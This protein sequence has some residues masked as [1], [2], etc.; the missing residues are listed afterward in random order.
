MFAEHFRPSLMRGRRGAILGAAIACAGCATY[1]PKPLTT[2]AVNQALA[3]PDDD[4]LHVQAHELHHPILAPIDLNLNDGLLPDEAAV[5]AVLMNPGLRAKRDERGLAQ[6]QVLQAG[7]LPNPQISASF[8]QPIGGSTAGTVTGFGGGLDYDIA[9]LITRGAQIDSAKAEAASIELDV[10]WQE[11]LVAEDAKLHVTR[12]M[13][14]QRQLD[15]TATAHQQAQE[16]AATLRNAVQR[17]MM[18]QVELDAAETELQRFRLMSLEAE[19][20]IERERLALNESIGLPAQTTI[21]IQSNHSPQ[22]PPALPLEQ[23]TEHL[24]DRR[25]DLMALRFGYESQEAKLRVAVLSQFPKVSV[26][27]AAAR[28]TGNVVSAGMGIT[29]D[30]PIFDRAQGAIS[31]ESATRQKLFDEY[32]ARLFEARSDIAKIRTELASAARKI[33]ATDAYVAN[34]QVLQQTYSTAVRNGAADIL[35]LYQLQNTLAD[36]RLEGM[37]LRQLQAEL[38]IG[39]ELAQGQIIPRAEP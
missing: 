34:L 24:E 16:H 5:L 23:I 1:Q 7:L 33:E 18:T 28:D 20:S 29:V 27:L 4:A 39:L 38:V 19:E 22:S 25:L 32:A 8:D 6:A 36:A 21:G 15:E 30:P 3:A 14:L 10:A 37:Q 2:D 12:L 11:W 13:W 31:I 9:A 35:S 26:G 17:Q